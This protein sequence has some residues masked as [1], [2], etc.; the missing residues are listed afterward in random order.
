M[1]LKDTCSCDSLTENEEGLALLDG[2]IYTGVCRSNY[3]NSEKKYITKDYMNGQLHGEV[4]FFDPTGGV[5]ME[6]VYTEGKKKRN[7]GG[8]PQNCDC[9]ELVQKTV[10]GVPEPRFMLDDLPFT[11]KCEEKYPNSDQTY[12]EIYYKD[13]LRDGFATYFNRNGGTMFMEK[14][15][16]GELIKTINEEEK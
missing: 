6:E 1:D 2:E 3:P 7:G 8:A 9:S 12:I 10:P 14:Y 16:N 15:E 5:L 4:T 13:G 11:G